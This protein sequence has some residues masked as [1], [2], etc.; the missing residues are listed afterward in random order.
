MLVH[1][2]I[3]DLALVERL[4]LKFAPGL[5]VLTGETG[6]GKSVLLS[7]MSLVLGARGAPE[8]VRSGREEAT[9]E[10]LF[11]LPPEHPALAKWD[12]AGFPAGDGQVSIARTVRAQGRGRVTVNGRP[13]TVGALLQL[14]QGVV[15]LTSQ[16]E[17]VA[18]LDPDAHLEM[19]DRFGNHGRL[20]ETVRRCHEVRTQRAAELGALTLDPVARDR[21]RE[22]LRAAIEAIDEANPT[23]GERDRLL[24]ERARLRH[25]EELLTGLSAIEGALYSSEGATVEVL[26]RVARRL[27][28]LAALDSALEP[29]RLT[30]SSL[31]AEVEELSRAVARHAAELEAEPGRLDEIER[32]LSTLER[33]GR[34]FGSTEEKVLAAR[35]AMEE[36]ALA[37]DEE[38]PRRAKAEAELAAAERLLA[39]ASSALSSARAAAA[40]RLAHAIGAAL[41]TL[42][43]GKTQ[44]ELQQLAL[45]APG[46]KGGETIELLFSPNPGEPPRSL[47]R[48]ASGGEL[49]RMLLAI[50]QVVRDGAACYVFDE[51][52]TGVGGAV[53]EVLGRRLAALA[54]RSQVIAVTHLPQVAAFADRHLRVSK[55]EQRGRAVTSVEPLDVA[56]VVTELARMLGGVEITDRTRALAEELRSRA[57]ARPKPPRRAARSAA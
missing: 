55:V 13:A 27:E 32:R 5:N 38:A 42:A 23:P 28:R 47:R 34:R 53:A 51:V 36:E 21:R 52:D 4:E 49:S 33:L 11:R 44:V 18:L 22:E 16:H 57:R 10:A 9:V 30:A 7:A 35:S 50:K 40:P 48:C 43:L 2:N 31:L 19:L 3:R 12:E 56:G 46:P 24:A 17:H 25:A 26:A 20:R 8:M 1:L 15:D 54:S 45:P 29:S 37:L 39:E 6:A 14:M 41:E